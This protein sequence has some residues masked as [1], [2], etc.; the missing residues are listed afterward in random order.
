MS[1]IT[2]LEWLLI[3]IFL[4]GFLLAMFD[5]EIKY[6]LVGFGLMVAAWLWLMTRI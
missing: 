4:G 3:F 2:H 5:E 6:R 1:I